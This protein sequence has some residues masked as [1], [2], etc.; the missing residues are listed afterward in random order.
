MQT[1]MLHLRSVLPGGQISGKNISYR[2]GKN[3][4]DW[5]ICV[6]TFFWPKSG[7]KQAGKIGQPELSKI[8]EN[9]K[10]RRET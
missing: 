5:K 9:V 4:L 7:R 2:A 3:L 10:Y 6:A 1:P 8:Y